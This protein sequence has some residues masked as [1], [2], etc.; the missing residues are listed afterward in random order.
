MKKL[1]FIFLACLLLSCA[2]TKQVPTLKELE[3]KQVKKKAKADEV[4]ILF[5]VILGWSLATKDL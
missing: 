1:L 3:Q 4:V 2:P 5:I